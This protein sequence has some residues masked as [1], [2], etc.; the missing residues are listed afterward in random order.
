MEIPGLMESALTLDAETAALAHRLAG[1]QHMLFLGRGV[2]HPV[3]LEG[4]LKLKEISYVHAEGYAAGEMKHGPIALIDDRMPVLALAPR[5]PTYDRMV[6]NIEEVRARDGRVIAVGNIG[7]AELAR[8][9]HE[10]LSVPAASG[11]PRAAGQRD[12]APAP[13]LPRRGAPRPGRG[14]A[15]QPGQERH[16]GV[17]SGPPPGFSPR[18]DHRDRPAQDAGGE[19]C[20]LVR[21]QPRLGPASSPGASPSCSLGCWCPADYGLFAMA[22]SVLM[23]LELLQEFGLG[24]AIIQKRDLTR[25]QVNGVFWVVTSMSLVLTAATFLAAGPISVL[26]GEPRLTWALQDPLPHVPAE[27]RRDGTVQPAHQGAQPAAA[28]DGRGDGRR[29]VRA[30]GPGV[31]LPGLRRVGPRAR[32]PRP[33][34][35][36][37]R[38]PA[39]LRGL[40][41]GV[42]RRPRRDAGASS[43]S[44][45]ASPGCTSS[46]TSRQ[47]WPHSS[48]AGCSVAPRWGSTAWPRAWPTDRTGSRP[49]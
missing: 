9:A 19:V 32:S 18:H 49:G 7:D 28:G 34:D 6:G 10:V 25:Q 44:A 39:R 48:W 4:A 5:D 41:P 31:R 33:R 38:S 23:V 2:H 35:R 29:R 13:G 47:R 45:C 16:G 30:R 17:G 22:L 46:A 21:G 24:V 12:P 42:R 37:Q 36:A 27:L 14:P 15:A 1:Y 40:D 20:R 8:R 43:R 11:S 26:Y 3:A